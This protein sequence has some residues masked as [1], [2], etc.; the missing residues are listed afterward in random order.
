MNSDQSTDQRTAENSQSSP[1]Q[2]IELDMVTIAKT[3]AKVSAMRNTQRRYFIDRNYNTLRQ[4]KALEQEVDESLD[5][6]LK[7][8]S[9]LYSLIR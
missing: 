5:K 9:R 8:S 1:G 2:S 3:L 4:A 6:A 7:A